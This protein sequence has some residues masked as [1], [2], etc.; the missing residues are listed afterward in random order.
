MLSLLD[1][2]QWS[3]P[4]KEAKAL[5]NSYGELGLMQTH[6]TGKALVGSSIWH[7]SDAFKGTQIIQAI[8]TQAEIFRMKGTDQEVN[9]SL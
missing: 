2:D 9:S 8:Y 6:I 7:Y 5:K 3:L 4:R 1:L